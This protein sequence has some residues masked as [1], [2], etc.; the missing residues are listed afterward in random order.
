MLVVAGVT[1]FVILGADGFPTIWGV[2]FPPPPD[3]LLAIWFIV[4]GRTARTGRFQHLIDADGSTP[5]TPGQRRP[6]SSVGGGTSRVRERGYSGS[7]G[8]P[9]S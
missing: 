5:K 4:L 7:G 2:T 3:Y 8:S 9:P 6:T 1:L